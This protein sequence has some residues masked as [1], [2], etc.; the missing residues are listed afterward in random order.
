[1]EKRWFFSKDS[2]IGDDFSD[3]GTETFKNNNDGAEKFKKFAREMVQNSIDVKDDKVKEPLIVKFDLFDA[4]IDDLPN[5]SG[6]KDHIN[7]TIDYCSQKNKLNNAYYISKQ[8][9]TLLKKQKIKILKISDYNTK[10]ICGSKKLNADK[11]SWAGLV[12]N[13]GDS[14]KSSSDSLGSHGLG[15]GAAF[16]MSNLRT[17]FYNTKDIE[18]NRALQGV[19]RQYVSY[20]NGEKE[21]YKGYFGEVVSDNVYPIYDDGINKLSK[22]FGRESNGSDVFI[23]EPD[24][25][26]ISEEWV[27]WYLIESVISNFFVA[28]RDGNLEV[29]INGT[30]VNQSNLTNIFS[31]LNEFY[32]KNSLEKSDTLIQTQQFLQT[33]DKAEPIA[34]NLKGYGEILLWLYKDPDTKWKNV[35]IVRKNGMFIRNLEVRNANQKFSGVVIV[36][37]EQGVEF[38]KSIEDPS[39]MDFDPS[40]ATKESFGSTE[41]KQSRLND[42]YDWIR[43]HAKNFTK[44][45]SED[46]L[47]LAGMEDYIQMPSNEEKKFSPKNVEPKVIKVKPSNNNPARVAKK[48]KVVTD[49]DGVTEV[50]NDPLSKGKGGK[51][52]PNPKPHETQKEDPES[53]RKGFVKTYVASFELGPVFKT[54]GKE[55]VLVFKITESNK[56]FKIKICAV[57]E[58]GN[59]NGLLPSIISA[60]DLNTNNPLT[61]NRHVISDVKCVDVMKLKVCFESNLNCCI[62]PVVYWEE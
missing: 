7:G 41:D 22:I 35:A 52:N 30:E 28:I 59:E 53:K 42:F 45:V 12:Y 57:D 20:V 49:D 14:V 3:H 62:K 32:E 55:A 36:K 13:D 38:L 6:L 15:K 18:G 19:T 56:N 25:A 24:V 37:G 4:N 29:I 44:I 61:V 21:F 31:L 10:G 9:E 43:N 8:E 27:K 46:K 40:R 51:P 23:L 39:H 16:S 47:T 33:L 34:E 54:N 11:S 1:M 5:F 60:I 2:A 48:T 58:D 17:V 26:Y 50:I